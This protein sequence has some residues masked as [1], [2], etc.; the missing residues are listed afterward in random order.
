MEAKLCKDFINNSYAAN[1]A[2]FKLQ[3]PFDIR[4]VLEDYVGMK[5]FK[6]EYSNTEVDEYVNKL[7]NCWDKFIPINATILITDKNQAIGKNW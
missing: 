2:L 5:E 6:E 3:D 7:K 4:K 1:T